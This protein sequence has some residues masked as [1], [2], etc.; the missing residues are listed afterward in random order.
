MAPQYPQ[1]KTLPAPLHIPDIMNLYHMYGP[2]LGQ[3]PPDGNA[4]AAGQALLKKA[5]IVELVQN[6]I[7]PSALWSH[8]PKPSTSHQKEPTKAK[9]DLPP[10]EKEKDQTNIKS[11][12]VK[13]IQKMN[14]DL[15]EKTKHLPHLQKKPVPSSSSPNPSSAPHPSFVPHPTF[16]SYSVA[17][18]QAA[19]A[20]AAAN[21]NQATAAD[22]K[23]LA[24]LEARLA[25]YRKKNKGPAHSASAIYAGPSAGQ[26]VAPESNNMD[27]EYPPLAAFGT[28]VWE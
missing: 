15:V 20:A 12:D 3:N 5:T 10:A 24:D 26:F 1:T 7:P 13:K 18:A 17:G 22:K 23:L 2:T 16:T 27:F 9:Q 14:W 8:H 19:A 28:G 25:P 21:S 6:G 11:T 4:L